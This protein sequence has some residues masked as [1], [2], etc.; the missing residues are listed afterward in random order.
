MLTRANSAQ[1][2]PAQRS[3][4]GSEGPGISSVIERFMD[5]KMKLAQVKDVE[6]GAKLKETQAHDL[7]QDIHSK[8]SQWIN[9]R[10]LTVPSQDQINK[11]SPRDRKAYSESVKELNMAM[12]ELQNAKGAKH[13]ASILGKI[14]T[15]KNKIL[16][17]QMVTSGLGT[18]AR[19]K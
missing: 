11:M 15:L 7:A 10:G 9:E 16:I 17:M 18:I 2:T 8:D 19:F 14:D 6:A 1:S 13:Q 3:D 12:K 4:V 5:T